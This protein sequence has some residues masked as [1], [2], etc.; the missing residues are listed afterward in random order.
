MELIGITAASQILLHTHICPAVLNICWTIEKKEKANSEG[1]QSG[2][3]AKKF[4]DIYSILLSLAYYLSSWYTKVIR[5]DIA[6][7]IGLTAY[8]RSPGLSFSS[9]WITPLISTK[10]TGY[11]FH[12]VADISQQIMDASTFSSVFTSEVIVTILPFYCGLVYLVICSGSMAD[13]FLMNETNLE[14]VL[15]KAHLW[16]TSTNEH[17]CLM[18]RGE[19]QAR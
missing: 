7:Q 12:S 6:G 11:F 8:K 19:L 15:Q 10:A 16:Y 18:T 14:G 17:W 13:R 9:V 5:I 2:D 3:K 4:T 1:E